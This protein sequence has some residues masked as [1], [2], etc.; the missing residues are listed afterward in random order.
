MSAPTEILLVEKIRTWLK[1]KKIVNVN[2]VGIYQDILSISNANEG[3]YPQNYHIYAKVKAVAIFQNLIE[4]EVLEI[5]IVNACDEN[6]TN[7]V[8]GS[9]PKYILPK[10]V[11][12]QQT[13]N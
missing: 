11:R 7:I 6:I 5:N 1:P 8:T 2:D 4:I 12:W 9:I 10:Y 3:V 13:T